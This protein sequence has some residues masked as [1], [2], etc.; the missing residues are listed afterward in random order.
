MKFSY[1]AVWDDTVGMLKRNG[2]LLLALAG[3]FFMLP[4]LLTGYLFPTPANAD[5][6]P[7]GA[8][9]AYYRENWLGLMIGSLVNTIGSAAIYLLL[10]DRRGGTVGSAIAAALPIVP[11]YFLMSLLVSLAIGFGFVLLVVPG[12]YLIGRLATS[13]TVMVAEGRRNPLNAIGGSWRLTK[14]KGWAV[15]GLV[16][17][18]GLA[19]AILS[20]AITAVLGSIFLLVGGREGVGGLL[21]L[22]LNSALTAV[23][24]T[25]LIVLLA[26]IYR[27]L[28]PDE[29]AV[30]VSA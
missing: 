2:S 12:I 13:G 16:L 30:A 6:D 4:A 9:F 18:V 20:F 22:I 1:S 17:I 23:L 27:R 3:V 11:F 29:S 26:A 14:G 8:M 19:G 21:V 7:V 5:A 10:F 15:A 28:A 24:Y 25:V